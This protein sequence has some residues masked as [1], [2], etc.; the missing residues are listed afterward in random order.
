MNIV[1]AFQM[2]LALGAPSQPREMEK[3]SSYISLVV[4]KRCSCLIYSLHSNFNPRHPE[5]SHFRRFF[6]HLFAMG[7]MIQKP[8]GT[9]GSALPAILIGG[10]LFGYVLSD[11]LCASQSLTYKDMTQV[12]S[13]VY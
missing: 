5:A 6:D 4:F 13:E 8:E 2:D 1:D 7:L 3:L 9:A 12:L 11:S 10:V